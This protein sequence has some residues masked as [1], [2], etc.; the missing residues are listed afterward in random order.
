MTGTRTYID[1][2]YIDTAHIDISAASPN[3]P[4][5]IFA[6]AISVVRR[7][8]PNASRLGPVAAAKV[9]TTS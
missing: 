2:T 8:G 5:L 7:L 1:M 9:Q 3:L 4:L 6:L